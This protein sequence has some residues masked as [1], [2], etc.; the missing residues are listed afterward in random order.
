MRSIALFLCFF[1]CV[2]GWC[3]FPSQIEHQWQDLETVLCK[4]K[5]VGVYI[6]DREEDSALLANLKQAVVDI[7]EMQLPDQLEQR[8]Q[9]DEDLTLAIIISREE[10][11]AFITMFLAGE[12]YEEEG[13]PYFLDCFEVHKDRIFDET[14]I[15]L[16]QRIIEIR[17]CGGS[18]K[19]YIAIDNDDQF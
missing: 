1:L 10:N 7:F 19:P 6:I 11:S 5:A 4:G 13:K 3:D 18:L 12:D 2:R 8:E 15:H 9:N 16:R 14:V 17:G